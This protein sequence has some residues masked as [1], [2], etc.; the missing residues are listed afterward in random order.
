MKKIF[1][2]FLLLLSFQISA[3]SVFLQPQC[4]YNSAEAECR[5]WN[6]SGRQVTCDM[7]IRIQTRNGLYNDYRHMYLFQGQ[8]SYYNVRANNPQ[9]DPI[10]YITANAFCNVV[11]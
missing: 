7:H 11:R 4:R 6:T 8:M 3:Q 1:C 10:T 5:L 2:L 9:I